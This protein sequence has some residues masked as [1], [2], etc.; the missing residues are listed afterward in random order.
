LQVRHSIVAASARLEQLEAAQ[1]EFKSTTTSVQDAVTACM[2]DAGVRI[3]A[4]EDLKRHVSQLQQIADCGGLMARDQLQQHVNL[5]NMLNELKSR[6]QLL[7]QQVDGLQQQQFRYALLENLQNLI[8]DRLSAVETAQLQIQQ[9]QTALQQKFDHQLE[10]QQYQ[11]QHC[12]HIDEQLEAKFAAL[13]QRVSQ[14][15]SD[16]ESWTTIEKLVMSSGNGIGNQTSRSQCA[17]GD[18]PSNFRDSGF[19]EICSSYVALQPP[20]AS[21]VAREDS[22]RLLL[23]LS[24]VSVH[25]RRFPPH[26]PQPTH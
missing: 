5:E 2:S 12:P 8:S 3:A 6:C 22:S 13:Q 1:L 9:C 10:L 24:A 21:A 4:I 19:D 18:V 7:E 15:E 14:L 23:Q 11:R 25:F 17:I 16:R 26:L 20:P